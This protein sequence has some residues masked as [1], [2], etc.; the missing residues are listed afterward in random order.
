MDDMWNKYH[1]GDNISD[2]ELSDMIRLCENGLEYLR[3]RGER[4]YLA[5]YITQLD[6]D[7]L[8]SYKRSREDQRV[9]LPEIKIN[10]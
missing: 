6:L 8:K 3:S 10:V 7:S 9:T 1:N 2:K 5:T 4:F